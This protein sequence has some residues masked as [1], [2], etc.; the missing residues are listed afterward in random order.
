MALDN[1]RTLYDIKSDPKKQKESVELVK[2]I[3][4]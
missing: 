1:H 2:I 4:V 3:H